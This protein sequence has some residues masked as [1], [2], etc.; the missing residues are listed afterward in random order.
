M[1][2]TVLHPH[3]PV[4]VLVDIESTGLK[5]HSDYIIQIAAKVEFT[6]LD[7]IRTHS[8]TESECK[9]T[10]TTAR[11]QITTNQSFG[12]TFDALCKPPISI[13]PESI[14]IHN[15][16]NN[17]VIW[18]PSTGP[19]LI[20]FWKWIQWVV[21]KANQGNRVILV[22]H[23]AH[24]FDAVMLHEEMKRNN[25]QIPAKIK[26]HWCD[27]L[28]AYRRE[29]LSPQYTLN[30]IAQ[31]LSV[32]KPGQKQSH[33]AEQDVELL[34]NVMMNVH[35]L[36]LFYDQLIWNTSTPELTKQMI[37]Q[38]REQEMKQKQKKTDSSLFSKMAS[39]FRI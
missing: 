4:I 32:L 15:I 11:F 25:I 28:I 13:P 36:K 33:T 10:K 9:Q 6:W 35:D 14:A 38:D 7:Q 5:P 39:S 30:A 26:V 37:M 12:L 8:F 29:F 31:R 34:Q 1:N 21:F 20:Q 27:S 2:Y 19:V 16:S 24:A 22:G 23:N 18:Q 17:D 3:T